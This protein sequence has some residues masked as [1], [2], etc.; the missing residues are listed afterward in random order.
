MIVVKAAQVFQRGDCN[1]DDKTD[2][3]D[4]AAVL[5][6]Q[7]GSYEIDCSDA[8]DVNDDGLLNMADS[9]S[10]LNWLFK[11]GDIPA[12]P[13]PFDDGADPTED[14]LPVCDSDDTNCG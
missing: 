2:L 11:F 7:F 8:C 3:A 4:A 10:L 5:A 14:S 12:A 13:G 1:S 9:V 6:N